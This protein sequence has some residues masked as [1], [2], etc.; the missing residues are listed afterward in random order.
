MGDAETPRRH[1]PGPRPSDERRT[2]LLAALDALLD[3]TPLAQ[4]NVADITRR[5]GLGRSAF[6]FYFESKP[7]AVAEMFGDF[8][9][10]IMNLNAWFTDHD[11]DPRTQLERGF[12]ANVDGWR[13]RSKMLVAMLDA[14]GTDV[15]VR[16]VWED[17]RVEHTRLVTARIQHDLATGRATTTSDPAALARLLMGTLFA[18]MED[19]VRDGAAGRPMDP[20]LSTTL[21]ELWF[22]SIYGTSDG[23]SASEG[24]DITT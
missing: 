7:A 20:R 21:A 16:Q 3:D 22:R 2:Q 23:L 13:E 5:A 8:Y 1:R 11:G 12:R 10:R 18:A 14:V 6:Y 19:D 17:R 24:T 15:S 9:V 4:V